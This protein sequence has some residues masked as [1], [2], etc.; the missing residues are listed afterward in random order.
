LNTQ[1][2]DFGAVVSKKPAGTR[3]ILVRHGETDWNREKRFQGHTDIAL[4]A[5]GL[6]QAA[7][8]RRY[9]DQIELTSNATLY[10]HCVSSDL[11]RAHTTA[12][13]IHGDKN[14]PIV[15]NANLRERH[16]GHL[17]GLTADEMQAKSPAEYQGLLERIPEAP[18]QGGESLDQFYQRVT[19]AFE[20]I[21]RDKTGQTVLVVAHGGVLDCIYRH[22]ME[23]PIQKQRSWQLPNCALNVIELDSQGVWNIPV[24]AWT[25]H[26]NLDA[27]GQNMDEV[28]GRIA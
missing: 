10:D 5:H 21:A 17:S 27:S 13:A 20:Q 19:E 24:W 26:L 6:N 14:P 8:I 11:G 9:F 12:K 25:G 16:Y 1:A 28:D 22:C 15:L 23:E 18:L 3:F 7:L 4:N 2:L